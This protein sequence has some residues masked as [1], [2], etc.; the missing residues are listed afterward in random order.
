[1]V[2]T[3]S[4]SLAVNGTGGTGTGGGNHGVHLAAAS[5]IRSTTGSVSLTAVGGNS[6]SLNEG[7]RLEAA[8]KISSYGSAP[9]SITAST[10]DTANS[11]AMT[12]ASANN[13]IGGTS[14]TG[15]ITFTLDS[16]DANSVG[17][18]RSAGA[19]TIRPS[20]LSTPINVATGSTGLQLTSAAL[21]ALQDGFSSITIGRADGTGDINVGT[22]SFMD[23][24][25]MA[26]G[27]D[28]TVSSSLGTG[29]GSHA[30]SIALRA[31]GD[32]AILG[33]GLSTYGEAIIL[34]ADRD[35]TDGGAIETSSAVINSHGGAI[36][37]GGG[38]DPSTTAAKGSAT[39]AYGVRLSSG[40]VSSE[41][42]NIIINGEGKNADGGHGVSFVNDLTLDSG[43]GTVQIKGKATATT[44]TVGGVVMD[45]NGNALTVRSVAVNTTAI[46]IEGDASAANATEAYGIGIR[47]DTDIKATG[48]AGGVTLTGKAGRSVT[49]GIAGVSILQSGGSPYIEAASGLINL[50]GTAG[51]DSDSLGIALGGPVKIGVGS[52]TG[53]SASNITLTADSMNLAQVGGAEIKS[54]GT[55][56]LRPETRSSSVGL[57]GGAGALSLSSASLGVLASGFSEVVIGDSADYGAITVGGAVT[58]ASPLRL[59]NAASGSGGVAING[60]LSVGTNRLTINSSGSVTQ[61]A[62]I[63]ADSLEMVGSG[64]SYTLTGANSV[65]TIA[66][67]VGSLAFRNVK[68]FGVSTVGATSGVTASGL[69]SLAADSGSV[70]QGDPINAASLELKG[71]DSHHSLVGANGVDVLAAN[72]TELAFRNTHGFAI[73]TAGSTTGVTTPG[74]LTSLSVD[75]GTVSQTA[76]ITA[77]SLELSGTSAHFTLTGAN[78]VD[79]LAGSAVDLAFRNTQGFVIGTA[80]GR[81]GLSTPG[82][83]LSLRADSGA[84]TQTAAVTAG[85]LELLGASATYTLSNTGN[86]VGQVAGRVGALTFR[87]SGTLTIGSAGGS[88]GVEVNGTTLGLTSGSG[89][90]QGFRPCATLAF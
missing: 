25:V 16:L 76:G 70:W 62:G 34:N 12:A 43:A 44:G 88:E 5:E 56:T 37:M 41:G 50:N 8:S 24:L 33:S 31:G 47:A 19:L 23:P 22:V 46:Q 85:N 15:A 90:I 28:I 61:T 63:T 60:A 71:T 48:S 89:S 66:A 35:A 20:T 30:G 42:G 67:N 9:I 18:V 14:A 36:T 45:G 4:G 87:N 53:G 68:G 84:V 39:R 40:S 80:G 59:V 77:G 2:R 51:T 58:F 27:G 64:A 73:G 69:A 11:I 55:L 74:A 82:A 13:T 81:S 72:V 6:G 29:S 7:L 79:A 57:A 10:P 32:V 86:S 38:A 3:T 1:M 54:S 83:L 78:T 21:G 65:N 17:T 75:A 26:T 52:R 49:A